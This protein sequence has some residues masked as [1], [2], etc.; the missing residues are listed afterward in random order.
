MKIRKYKEKDRLEI[1]DIHFKT[2]FLGESMSKFL[3]NNKIWK[4]K[5][6]YFFNKEKENIFVLVDEKRVVGYLLGSF[7]QS[8]NEKLSYVLNTFKNVFLSLYGSRISRIYWLN[9]F[10]L[11][12]KIILR[13]SKEYKFKTPKNAATFHINIRPKY[14]RRGFGT[15]LLKIFV[16]HAKSN[17]VN[18]IYAVS[19]LRQ[20]NSNKI[21]WLKNGFSF[22][23]K[24][25]TLAWQKYLHNEDIFL[26]CYM[27]KIV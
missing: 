2:G 7:K 21:F 18:R 25:K 8:K 13:M 3:S 1:E 5:I 22:Y 23:S 27:K 14:R 15:K 12:I 20:R 11:L 16:K 17:G 26:I 24:V 9:E 19:Y 6:N 10:F 4:E